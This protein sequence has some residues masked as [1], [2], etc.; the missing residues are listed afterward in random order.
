MSRKDTLSMC[1]GPGGGGSFIFMCPAK[2]SAMPGASPGDL[3]IG[4]WQYTGIL[5]Y[6]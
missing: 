6:G 3:D 1:I 4:T 5:D 2:S